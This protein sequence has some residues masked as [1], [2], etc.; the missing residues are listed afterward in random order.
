MKPGFYTADQLSNADYHGGEGVSN[1]GLKLIGDKT[2]FHFW[3]RYLSPDRPQ[4][5]SS[6]PQMIG[7]AIH[8]AALEPAR[9]DEQYV[10]GQFSARNAK[11]YKAWAEEQTKHIL[12][13]DEYRNVLG[14]R[15]SLH[16]HPV[17]GALLRSPGQFEYSVYANDPETGVL[18]RVRFDLLLDSG[19]CVDLKKCQDASAFGAAKAMGNYGYFHQDAFYQDVLTWAAGEPPRGFVFI[20]V[21]EEWPHAVGVY[22]L[23]MDDRARGRRLYRQNLNTYAHCLERNVWPSYSEQAVEIELNSWDRRRIDNNLISEIY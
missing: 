2:P 21:E 11:G 10:V 20:F 8:A 3:G 22:C 5:Q 12:L 23:T 9:F 14:M 16:Q 17:A 4:F 19:Y 18:V 7:T 1:S 15:R 6:K 13:A